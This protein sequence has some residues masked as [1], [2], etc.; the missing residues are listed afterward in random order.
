[1]R[2]NLSE[3]ALLYWNFSVVQ[4]HATE[5]RNACRSYPMLY[6]SQTISWDV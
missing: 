3:S 6:S 2:I 1:L 4:I 5:V